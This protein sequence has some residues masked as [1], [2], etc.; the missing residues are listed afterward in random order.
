M[1]R[2]KRRENVKNF[3]KLDN[4]FHEIFIKACGNEKLY[5]PL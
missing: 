2:T 3:F 1:K 4:Q 5:M